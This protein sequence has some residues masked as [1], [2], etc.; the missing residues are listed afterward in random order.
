MALIGDR[1]KLVK[2]KIPSPSFPAPFSKNG[3]VSEQTPSRS[4]NV[5]LGG[6]KKSSSVTSGEMLEFSMRL[7]ASPI[8]FR[9]KVLYVNQS[10]D[11]GYELGISIEEMNNE[12]RVAWTKFVIQKWRQEGI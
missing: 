12:D 4:R 7:G 2:A 11:Q 5:G 8:T 10:N 1:E 3:P 9:G 6:V